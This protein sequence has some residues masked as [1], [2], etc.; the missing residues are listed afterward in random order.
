MSSSNIRHHLTSS[1]LTMIEGV[2]LKAGFSGTEASV[3][4][5]ALSDAGRFLIDLFRGGEASEEDLLAALEHRG[6]HTGSGRNMTP[7]QSSAEALDRW[8]DEG[9]N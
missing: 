9:G 6:T 1:D 3:D 5:D 7:T 8:A 4:P 2:L